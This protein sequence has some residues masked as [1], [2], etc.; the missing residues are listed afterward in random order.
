[1][2]VLTAVNILS[3]EKDNKRI[4]GSKMATSVVVHS[5]FE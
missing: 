2:D 3:S 1:M 4:I 5:I